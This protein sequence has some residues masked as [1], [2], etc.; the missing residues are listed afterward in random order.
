MATRAYILI[1]TSVGRVQAVAVALRSRSQ[2]ERTDPVTGPYDVIA[3]VTA[4]DLNAVAEFV[5]RHVHG[6]DGIVRTVSCVSVSA[7]G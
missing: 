3:V 5:T 6:I 2:V 4:P 7:D 1:E